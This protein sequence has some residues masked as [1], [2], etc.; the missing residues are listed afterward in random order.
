MINNNACYIREYT[1]L[2]HWYYIFIMKLVEKKWEYKFEKYCFFIVSK[3]WFHH[4]LTKNI[5][6]LFKIIKVN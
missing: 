5:K 4:K 6:K 1:N 3:N 2:I